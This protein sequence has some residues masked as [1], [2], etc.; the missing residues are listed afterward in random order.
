MKNLP[1]DLLLLP[2]LEAAGFQADWDAHSSVA[3]SFWEALPDATEPDLIIRTE[4][5]LIMIEVKHLSTLGTDKSQLE[6]EVLGGLAL[7]KTEGLRFSF[8][9]LTNDYKEPDVLGEFKAAHPPGELGYRCLWTSWRKAFEVVETAIVADSP[10]GKMLVDLLKVMEKRGLRGFRGFGS[11]EGKIM[12]C[13]EAISLLD[14]ISRNISSMFRELDPLLEN[15]G[16]S[17]LKPFANTVIRDG[18]YRNLNEPQTWIPT[19]FARAYRK[20][21][22]ETDPEDA[23]YFI[24]VRLDEEDP[25]LIVGGAIAMERATAKTFEHTEINRFFLDMRNLPL[26][27]FDVLAIESAYDMSFYRMGGYL[28]IQ[29][30]ESMMAVGKVEDLGN[31]TSLFTEMRRVLKEAAKQLSDNA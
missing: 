30:Q 27:P 29:H 22:G 7:A 17:C 20:T 15:I 25:R 26:E 8:I 9:A 6:R 19:Y 10:H 16:F 2:W 1:E 31:I 24:K 5:D 3:F 28:I 14:E 12:K 23:L 18:A 11:L 4:H 21:L 13:K